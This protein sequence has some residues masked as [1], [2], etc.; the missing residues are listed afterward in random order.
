MD[1]QIR[2]LTPERVED[3]FTFFNRVAFSD[4]PEW[5][6]GCYC[7]FF[8]ATD[9]AEWDRRT[10]EENA[11]EARRMILADQMRGLLAY[12]GETPVGW[13]HFDR[14]MNLPGARVFYPQVAGTDDAS[15][16]IVCFTIAQ[17]YRGRG[18]A[19]ALLSAALSAL[20]AEGVARVEAYPMT[21]DD[22]PEHNYHGPLS[23]YRKLGFAA[24]RADAHNT[25]VEKRL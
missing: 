17:G 2:P 6:C 20:K 14:L 22:D 19:T 21:Q 16:A 1:W 18:L 8:H 13:L 3:F 25:L 10:P 4:H 24:V 5:G 9:R 12:D 7:C 23:L 15:A 11:A